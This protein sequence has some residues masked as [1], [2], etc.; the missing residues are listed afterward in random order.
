[1]L[2]KEGN[3]DEIYYDIIYHLRYYIVDSE[4][5]PFYSVHSSNIFEANEIL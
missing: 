2:A 3:T 5:D 1:M 4:V